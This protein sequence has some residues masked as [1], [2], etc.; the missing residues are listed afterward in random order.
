M[1]KTAVEIKY[2]YT[3]VVKGDLILNQNKTEV[4]YWEETKQK[5]N[6][7]NKKKTT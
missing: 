5:Q 4:D 3:I 7:T 1:N 6:Q 2:T